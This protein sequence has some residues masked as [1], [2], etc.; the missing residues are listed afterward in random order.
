MGARGQF[1]SGTKTVV[2]VYQLRKGTSEQR[3]YIAKAINHA[4]RPAQQYTLS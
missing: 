2:N 1:E 3:K 4:A